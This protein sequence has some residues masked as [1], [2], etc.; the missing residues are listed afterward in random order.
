MAPALDTK[1]AEQVVATFFREMQLACRGAY[2]E[3]NRPLLNELS[4]R[5]NNLLSSEIKNFDQH[6][7]PP[8]TGAAAKLSF[9]SFPR[10]LHYFIRHHVSME[11]RNQL[12]KNKFI[13]E[14]YRFAFSPHDSKFMPLLRKSMATV[15]R[16]SGKNTEGR[17]D[18]KSY[19]H[20]FIDRLLTL[21]DA[22]ITTL[23]R[24]IVREEEKALT[25]A[26][27][28]AAEYL[29]AEG[30]SCLFVSGVFSTTWAPTIDALNRAG[31]HTCW[32][33]TRDLRE[34]SGYGAITTQEIPTT[35]KFT[36]SFLGTILFMATA[37]KGRTLLN[38]ESYYGANWMGDA[39]WTL[40]VLTAAVAWTV[41]K[42]RPADVRNLY[43][44]MYDGL[45]PLARSN[46]MK[47][48]ISRAY[49]HMMQAPDRIIYNSNMEMFGDYIEHSYGITQPRLHFPR[50][51]ERPKNPKPRLSFGPNGNEI[52]MVC[53]TVCLAEFEEPSRDAG[54]AFVRDVLEQGIHFHYY[55]VETDSAIEKFRKTL[56][57]EARTR[58]H[59]HGLIK[60]QQAL[61]DDIHQFH[62]AFNPADHMPF[63]TGISQM[64]DRR[65]QDGMAM[66]WQSTIGTSFLVYAAA[67]LP[68]ILPRGCTGAHQLLPG[69]VIP[70]MMAESPGIRSLLTKL[71]LPA[72]CAELEHGHP[73]AIVDT[74]IEELIAF[75]KAA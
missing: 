34:F 8:A 36:V 31:W 25:I 49:E 35:Q 53:I 64:R 20:Y 3:L 12:K 17:G 63:A 48:E 29:A 41:R 27:N 55:C 19:A 61:V 44:F 73:A 5:L 30:D 11:L 58:F 68:F 24:N 10:K 50:Y 2:Q 39:A 46:D 72:R 16:I 75:L 69:A 66:F 38:S 65:Y 70:L 60:D 7:L 14:I 28:A 22:D 56:S 32:V 45:K 52:H 9:S 33:G 42:C 51:S 1:F 57:P 37:D 26:A 18:A 62:V 71:D 23:A 43:L 54:P 74:H 59:T 40:Y 13:F 21:S 47:L 6:F 67:G 4:G 15:R